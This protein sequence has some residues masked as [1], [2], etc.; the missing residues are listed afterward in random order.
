MVG[1]FELFTSI[2][3]ATGADNQLHGLIYSHLFWLQTSF[4]ALLAL[5]QVLSGCMSTLILTMG[6]NNPLK[7]QGTNI[8]DTLKML[9]PCRLIQET[10][11]HTT[12]S[13]KNIICHVSTNYLKRKQSKISQ[14]SQDVCDCKKDVLV[15]IE[16]HW[17]LTYVG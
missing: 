13:F 17:Y 14:V 3:M 15:L 7:E 8:D 16:C 6:P 10:Q 9:A 12:I 5:F 11:A 2:G 1:S 4:C